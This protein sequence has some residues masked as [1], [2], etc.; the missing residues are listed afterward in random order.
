MYVLMHELSDGLI[1][2][3]ALQVVQY[4]AVGVAV[5]SNVHTLQWVV[6]HAK[7]QTYIQM[8]YDCHPEQ[9]YTKN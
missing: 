7:T 6:S 4:V 1:V 2:Y 8:L 9:D 3:R 5:A